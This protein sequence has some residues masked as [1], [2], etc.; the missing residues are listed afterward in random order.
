MVIRPAA[1][2][3]EVDGAYDMAARIFGPN[4]PE[5]QARLARI[6]QREAPE[7][8]GD[9]LIATTGK[10][11]VGMTH[12]L[13]RPVYLGE[14][15]VEAFGLGHVCIH[16]SC[17]GQGHGRQLVLHALE[18]VRKKGG[19]L[20]IV[21]ARRAADGFYWNYGFVGI[22][23][24]AEVSVTGES[25]S[26]SPNK[27][28][29]CSAGASNNRLSDYAQAYKDTYESLPYAFCR[30][31]SWWTHLESRLEHASPD[32]M[33]VNVYDAGRWVGYYVIAK[34][35]VIEAAAIRSRIELLAEA[36]I[37]R[38]ERTQGLPVRLALSL[39]HPCVAY[40]RRFVHTVSLRFAWNGGHMV[41]ILDRERFLACWSS[42]GKTVRGGKISRGSKN[43]RSE[44]DVASHKGARNLLL[45]AFGIAPSPIATEQRNVGGESCGMLGLHP[46]WSV[47]DEF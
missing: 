31:S 41:R 47:L 4:Y 26:S 30:A 27:R 9:V 24:F 36:L 5:A 15:P 39:G 21:V 42:S 17:Q 6:R 43:S 45:T 12:V 13:P 1:S 46:V 18:L 22:D 33:L 14:R 23:S 3:E 28:I 19:V 8:A 29:R 38:L 32:A 20:A 40:A 25:L 2:L 34:G 7:A 10:K 11:I 37:R 16:P 35:V 44:Y